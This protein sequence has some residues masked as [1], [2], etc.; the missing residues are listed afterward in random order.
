MHLPLARGE[1]NE[2]KNDHCTPYAFFCREGNILKAKGEGKERKSLISFHFQGRG[3]EK[4]GFSQQRYK[5]APQEGDEPNIERGKGSSLSLSF[6]P[7]NEE[8]TGRITGRKEHP[9]FLKYFSGRRRRAK[10]RRRGKGLVLLRVSSSR[11]ERGRERALLTHREEEY[12]A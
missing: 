1:E 9:S 11:E 10:R 3:R 5:L 6:I 4:G 7:G 2:K 12:P 8:R